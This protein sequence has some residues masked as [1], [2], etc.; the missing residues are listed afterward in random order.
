[1]SNNQMMMILVTIVAII[2]PLILVMTSIENKTFQYEIKLSDFESS[3]AILCYILIPVFTVPFYLW[4]N[5]I[6]GLGWNPLRYKE[7][8]NNKDRCYVQLM[9]LLSC[10]DEKAMKEVREQFK[11]KMTRGNLEK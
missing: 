1:M 5:A 10:G 6:N 4:G 9:T 11:S 2:F 7:I 3:S 8:Q